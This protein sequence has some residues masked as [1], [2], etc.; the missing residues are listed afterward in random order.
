MCS[1]DLT[2]TP[3][4]APT[5]TPTDAPTGTPTSAPTTG[6]PTSAPTTVVSKS[7]AIMAA[8]MYIDFPAFSTQCA[9]VIPDLCSSDPSRSYQACCPSGPHR[10]TNGVGL[11]SDCSFYDQCSTAVASLSSAASL[12][13]MVERTE[14]LGTCCNYTDFFKD[15]VVGADVCSAVASLRTQEITTAKVTEVCTGSE[16]WLKST[17]QAMQ[18]DEDLCASYDAC[19]T[20]SW[21]ASDVAKRETCCHENALIKSKLLSNRN[22]K[23]CSYCATPR[24]APTNNTYKQ[25]ITIKVHKAGF[26][27]IR[28]QILIVLC[29]FVKGLQDRAHV[30]HGEGHGRRWC[31]DAE[32]GPV[33]EEGVEQYQGGQ[34]RLFVVVYRGCIQFLASFALSG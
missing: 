2:R 11:L 23:F 17:L 25:L 32:R 13:E 1:S 14:F 24:L 33:A 31:H 15:I 18:S 19:I 27:D 30:L 9:A 4:R 7:Q 12:S 21:S 3:T 22:S 28:D 29:F 26:L 5:A 6:A 8:A 16:T 34:Q 10:P 20:Q